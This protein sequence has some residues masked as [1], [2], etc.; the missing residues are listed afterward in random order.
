MILQTARLRLDVLEPHHAELLFAGL[1]DE[2][3]Y[4]FCED[5]PPESVASLAARYARLA[6]QCS[7]DGSEIW[8]NWSI[9]ARVEARYVGFVQATV[10]PH[11]SAP[12]AYRLVR[13]AWGKG[14][15]REAA[16][17]MLAHVRIV[18]NVSEFIATVDARNKRSI[19]TRPSVS[20]AP[21]CERRWNRPISNLAT[22]WFTPFARSQDRSCTL[23]S[24]RRRHG[25][26]TG[27]GAT[28]GAG[29]ALAGFGAGDV[30]GTSVGAMDKTHLSVVT[31]TRR[32]SRS[33][34]TLIRSTGVVS[35]VS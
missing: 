32:A 19:A 2:Q 3:L 31:I 5:E 13:D 29:P 33:R 26:V 7:P 28:T 16:T 35:A 12:I 24:P 6:T 25:F 21:W 22:K 27:R 17:A 34:R 14:Y 10:V 15:A 23:L 4:E 9:W 8:L 18:W 11:G 20:A 1:R 30:S